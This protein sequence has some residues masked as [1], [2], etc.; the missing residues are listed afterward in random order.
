[1]MRK[2]ENEPKEE[3]KAHTTDDDGEK[4]EGTKQ[5]II[6]KKTEAKQL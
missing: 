6:G 1:M 3:K 4:E 2:V 5:A